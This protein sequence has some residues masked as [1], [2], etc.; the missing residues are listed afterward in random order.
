MPNVRVEPKGRDKIARAVFLYPLSE[1]D[2]HRI[3]TLVREGR[4]AGHRVAK[5]DNGVRVVV[6]V[7]RN[8]PSRP[9][10]GSAA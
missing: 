10:S 9:T 2:E 8:G 1:R 6:L 5:C 4:A 3:E 7:T